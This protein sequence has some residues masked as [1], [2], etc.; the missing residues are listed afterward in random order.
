[1]NIVTPAEDERVH[2]RVCRYGYYTVSH[3]WGP[4]ERWKPWK[5]HGILGPNGKPM[6]VKILPEKQDT[7][8]KLLLSH[9]GFWW[10]DVFCAQSKTPPSIM[11]NVYTFCRICYALIDF[12]L[13]DF[14]RI[15]A[16]GSRL[17]LDGPTKPDRRLI[18]AI[19]GHYKQR[20]HGRMCSRNRT[21]YEALDDLLGGWYKGDPDDI[22]ALADFFSCRWFTRVWT[23]Q[24]YVLPDELVFI[25]ESDPDL[26]DINRELT[27]FIIRILCTAVNKVFLSYMQ[28]D[29]S[30]EHLYTFNSM[31]VPEHKYAEKSPGLSRCYLDLSQFDAIMIHGYY[32]SD[33]YISRGG[34]SPSLKWQY[35]Y[36]TLVLLL[37]KL[38]RMPR[39]CMYPRDYIY[40]VSGLLQL[41]M[42]IAKNEQET[43]EFFRK[44]VCD[45]ASN[46]KIP[47]SFA[48]SDAMSLQDVYGTLITHEVPS[49]QNVLLISTRIWY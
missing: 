47:G 21:W 48:L 4:E 33:K 17:G 30:V 44:A 7:I 40:G 12:R 23:L 27:T 2:N 3:L 41:D 37:K 15:Q 32:R 39:T 14:W 49:Y 16:I 28:S 43:W 45:R 5:D 9:P 19:A 11:G 26:C 25:G 31:G 22:K 6:E 24:E 8:F 10:I 38:A 13:N 36:F 42:E 20:I 35:K 18:N 29:T 1:M 46:V 34:Y